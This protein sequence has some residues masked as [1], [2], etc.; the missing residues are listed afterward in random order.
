MRPGGPIRQCFRLDG[1]ERSTPRPKRARSAP[2]RP[3]S[4]P[5]GEVARLLSASVLGRACAVRMSL[6]R[7][8][9]DSEQFSFCIKTCRAAE[10]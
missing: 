4:E 1:A 6:R 10:W 2:P 7:D 5:Q 9:E 3:P 8:P